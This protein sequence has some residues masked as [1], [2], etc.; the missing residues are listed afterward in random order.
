MEGSTE[1]S[2]RQINCLEEVSRESGLRL[3]Y[4]ELK[5]E[6]VW[7]ARLLEKVLLDSF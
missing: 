1:Q 3:G 6:Q 5:Q 4:R 7:A 2:K